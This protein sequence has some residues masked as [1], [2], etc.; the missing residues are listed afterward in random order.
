[1]SQ[2]P[3]CTVLRTS[4]P[5][6]RRSTLPLAPYLILP[7]SA[8]QLGFVIIEPSAPPDHGRTSPMPWAADQG[9]ASVPSILPYPLAVLP[10]IRYRGPSIQHAGPKTTWPAPV[11]SAQP[12]HVAQSSPKTRCPVR[13]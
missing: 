1:M 6:P 5:P 13:D 4:S 9:L 2:C 8:W 11:L 12:T 3:G 7:P 10:F